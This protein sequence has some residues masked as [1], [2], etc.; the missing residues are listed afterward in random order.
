[1]ITKFG[2]IPEKFYEDINDEELTPHTV[3]EMIEL[4]KELPSSLPMH[5]GY[6]NPVVSVFNITTTPFCEITEG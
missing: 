4:L 6:G 1:M 2:E 3:G 5:Q